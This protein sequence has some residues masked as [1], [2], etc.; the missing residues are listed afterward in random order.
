MHT[1]KLMESETEY[2]ACPVCS[3]ALKKWRAKQTRFG[4]YRMDV[5]CSCGFAFVNP[6]PSLSFLMEFYSSLGFGGEQ[7]VQEVPTKESVLAQEAEDPNSTVDA[8]RLVSTINELLGGRV[9][10]ERRFLDVGCGYGFF[11]TEAIRGGFEVTALDLATNKRKVAREITGMDPIATSFEDYDCSPS[12]FSAV[13]MSQI[14]EHV[15]DVNMW[16][17]KAHRIL[18]KDGILAVALPNFGNALRLLFQERSPYI[19]PPEHLNFF[20]PRSLS[21][22]MERHGFKVERVQWVTRVPK[23]I[24]RKRLPRIVSPLF[25]VVNALGK[26]A[27]STFDGLHLG[28]MISVYGRKVEK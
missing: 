23:R 4:N 27:F 5:C 20:N 14:L 21:T 13:L 25:P 19:I 10:G 3:G 11:S 15:S 17:T 12:T 2:N 18:V 7:P 6:R 26:I 22:L 24:I 9:D 1:I 16:M 8:S 28:T